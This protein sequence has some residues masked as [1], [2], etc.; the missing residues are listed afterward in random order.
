MRGGRRS[1]WSAVSGGRGASPCPYRYYNAGPPRSLGAPHGVRGPSNFVVI[2]FPD[3]T[4]FT[5][6]LEIRGD[7]FQV[8]VE[9]ARL[10]VI[11]VHNRTLMGGGP[12]TFTLASALFEHLIAQFSPGVREVEIRR[13]C[14]AGRSVPWAPAIGFLFALNGFGGERGGEGCLGELGEK[15][16]W[17]DGRRG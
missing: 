3:V 1:G 17:T 13:L 14:L 11:D 4:V 12:A 9:R 8:R 15:H 6:D 16:Y 5:E 10:D 7:K 2:L